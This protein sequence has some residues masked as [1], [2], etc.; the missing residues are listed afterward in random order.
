MQRAWKPLL[1]LGLLLVAPVVLAAPGH[2]A[3]YTWPTGAPPCNDISDLDIC[4]NVGVDSG[5]ILEIAANAIPAQAV[6]MDPAE[7]LTVRPAPGFTPVFA[8][9]SVLAFLGADVDITVVVEGLTFEEGTISAL[10]DGSGTFDVTI[11]GNTFHQTPAF[12]EAIRVS[13]ASSQPP[14]GPVLFLVEN[15]QIEIDAGATDPVSAIRIG[16]LQGNGNAGIV[17]NNVIDQVGGAQNA[18]ISIIN[19]D[20][21]LAVDVIANRVSGA[22]FNA[23]VGI[24]QSDSGGSVAGNTTARVIDNTVRGQVDY[25]GQPGGISLGV[26]RGAGTFTVVNN[27]VAFNESGIVIDGNASS[28]A[29]ITGIVANNIVAFNGD[30]GLFIEDDF[31]S[32]IPNEFNLVFGNGSDSFTPGPGTIAADPLLVSPTEFRT[33]AGSPARDSGSN[34]R[35][36][37]DITTDVAGDPRILGIVDM[38]AFE[39][40]VEPSILAIPALSNLGLVVLALLV[41]GVAWRKLG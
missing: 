4:L 23:G 15:N 18:A 5:D 1:R 29:A 33:V 25:A 12:G 38:G 13:S 40:S 17:R 34:A 36:P 27:T 8:G 28:G 22:N 16:D 35:V 30:G 26:S 7:S 32:T 9:F 10:Q 37:P 14:Y 19:G 6:V 11:R 39:E 3:V 24:R 2:A 41:I 31:A 21:T 20:V